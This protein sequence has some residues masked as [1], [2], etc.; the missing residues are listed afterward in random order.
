MA[1]LHILRLYVS[2][3]EYHMHALNIISWPWVTMPFPVSRIARGIQSH[4]LYNGFQHRCSGNETIGQRA[5]HAIIDQ[6]V[7]V[8]SETNPLC[9]LPDE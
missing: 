3:L 7:A 8:V 5:K 1:Q 6:G 4:L 9:A 2:Y